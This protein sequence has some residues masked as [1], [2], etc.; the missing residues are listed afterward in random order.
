[1]GIRFKI[2]FGFLTLV[3]MLFIAGVWSIYELNSIGS[4][5]PKML[6]ENYQSIHAA[7]KMIEALEREDSAV[8]LLLLGKA[9]KGRS[10]L[11]TADSL[12][13]ENYKLA[14]MNITIPGEQNHLKTIMSRYQNI[15]SYGNDR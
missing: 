8:L 12:F 13:N 6:D 2:L 9:D 14:Y 5:I 3:I 15:R 1:M 7:K 10:L 11:L 4:F